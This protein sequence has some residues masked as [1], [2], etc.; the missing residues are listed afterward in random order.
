MLMNHNNNETNH[1]KFISYTGKFPNLCSGIL[2]L[3]IDGNKYK[4]GHSIYKEPQGEFPR[5]WRSGGGLLPNYAG[6]YPGEWQIDVSKL[7]EHFRKCAT[8]IDVV[9]NDNVPCGCCGGCI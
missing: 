2:T 3:E 8:E 9:F 1:V 7:P 4:F 5:F 6:A